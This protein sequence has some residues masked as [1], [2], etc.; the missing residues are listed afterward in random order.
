VKRPNS[1]SSSRASAIV[2][3]ALRR[4]HH[5]RARDPRDER[6]LSSCPRSWSSSAPASAAAVIAG[7][8]MRVA[9]GSPA[10]GRS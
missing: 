2:A 10:S 6:D 4:H 8:S 9:S 1:V 7:A 3:T 5:L